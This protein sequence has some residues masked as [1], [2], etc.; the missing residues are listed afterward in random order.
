MSTTAGGVPA[1]SLAVIGGSGSLAAGFP[2]E[3]HAE[4]RVVDA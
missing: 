4:A 1:A 2:G 3:L